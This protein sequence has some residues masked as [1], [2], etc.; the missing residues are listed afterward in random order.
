MMLRLHPA[1]QEAE[2]RLDKAQQQ[3]QAAILDCQLICGHA[4]VGVTPQ[5]ESASGMF[6]PFPE[7]RVCLSCGLVERPGQDG[8]SQLAVDQSRLVP[9]ERS[10]AYAHTRV[11]QENVK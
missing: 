3:V 6:G 9:I 4:Q 2:A 5:V 8:Y 10:D 1:I 7:F 11:I